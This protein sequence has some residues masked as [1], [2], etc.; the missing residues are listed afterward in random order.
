[1]QGYGTG[2]PSNRARGSMVFTPAMLTYYGMAVRWGL[3]L[4]RSAK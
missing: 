4:L 2:N 1:M 3:E